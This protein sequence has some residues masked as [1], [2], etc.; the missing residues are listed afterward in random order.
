M[1]EQRIQELTVAVRDLIAAMSTAQPARVESVQHE[2]AEEAVEKPRRGRPK[3][4]V[5]VE[6]EAATEVAPEVEP[7][8]EETATE[9]V[10]EVVTID[11]LR[12]AI[13]DVIVAG[14]KDNEGE[15]R[16]KIAGVLGAFKVKTLPEL[17][18]SDYPEV[19]AKIRSIT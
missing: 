4:V 15:Y 9:V 7:E 16:K 2:P 19:L 3:K 11:T 5:E 6:P 17:A 8:I 10:E 13:R 1:L 14:G 18:E 12:A